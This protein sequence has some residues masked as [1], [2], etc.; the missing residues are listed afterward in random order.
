MET[1]DN[2]KHDGNTEFQP[3]RGD[4]HRGRKAED[5]GANNGLND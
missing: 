1:N 3:H 2:Q 4:E 5:C